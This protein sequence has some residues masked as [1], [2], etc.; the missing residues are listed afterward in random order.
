MGA[1]AA[2]M[3]AVSCVSCCCHV[4]LYW[5]SKAGMC[6][7]TSYLKNNA[8]HII[9]NQTVPCSNKV[10][11]V[12]LSLVSN[13]PNV[14]GKTAKKCIRDAVQI[15]NRMNRGCV[16]CT[17]ANISVCVCACVCFLRQEA[18]DHERAEEAAPPCSVCTDGRYRR[19][20]EIQGEPPPSSRAS[21]WQEETA[22][23]CR[24]PSKHTPPL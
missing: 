8:N 10:E 5:N 21:P 12:F 2:A 1:F 17:T 22:A 6:R 14:L 13:W 7:Q 18:E 16:Q 11:K 19:L 15:T 20:S 9:L 4:L 3:D 24:P 23:A